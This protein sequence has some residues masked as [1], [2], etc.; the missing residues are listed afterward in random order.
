MIHLEEE[1]LVHAYYGESDSLFKQHIEQCPDCRA[2]YQRLKEPIDAPAPSEDGAWPAA[3]T[4][5]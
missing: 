4:R 2:A 3:R 1:Q 5:S